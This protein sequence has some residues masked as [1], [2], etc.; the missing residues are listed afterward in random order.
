[1][2]YRILNSPPGYPPHQNYMVSAYRTPEFQ[3]CCGYVKNVDGSG[4]FATIEEARR[5]LPADAKQLPFQP[6]DQF[7]ELWELSE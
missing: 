6:V 2:F 1:M 4:F 3:S 7:L 5:A